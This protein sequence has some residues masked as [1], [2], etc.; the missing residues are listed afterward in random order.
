MDEKISVLLVDDHAV[1][2]TGF[3]TYLGLSEHIGSVFE[4]DRCESACRIYELHRPRVVVMDLSM[5]GIGGFEV[6]RRLLSRDPQCKILVFSIH[7]ELIYVSRAIKAGVKGYLVKSSD[8]E[9]LITAVTCIAAGGTFVAPVL[10]QKLAMNTSDE[11]LQEKRI[12]QLTPREFDIFC[13]L[14]KG[15]STREVAEQLF[16]SHKTVCNNATTIKDKLGIKTLSELALLANR[17]GLI[18]EVADR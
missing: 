1:V 12:K 14:A 13:L 11:A 4:S 10:A 17:H 3:K 9:L 7:D 5:P 2:R 6:I 15:K 8:P 18:K 16:V